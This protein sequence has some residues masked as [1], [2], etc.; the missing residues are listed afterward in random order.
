MEP[1]DDFWTPARI[2]S[3]TLVL[4]YAEGC[5]LFLGGLY[6]LQ[7][8][9]VCIL[10]LFC[11]WFPD[12]MGNFG[13]SRITHPTPPIVVSLGGWVLLVVLPVVVLIRFLTVGSPGVLIRP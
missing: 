8:L 9:S 3:L 1:D 11:I 13:G 2:A 10:P 4:L 7:M 5:Y 12:G 6:A